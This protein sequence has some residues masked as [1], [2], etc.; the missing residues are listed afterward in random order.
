MIADNAVYRRCTVSHGCR[1]IETLIKET[2]VRRREGF[3]Y[4]GETKNGLVK[5]GKSIRQ[6]PLCRMDQNDL[7]YLGLVWVPDASVFE[8]QLISA[9]GRPVKGEEWF[10]D[11]FRIRDLIAEGWLHG[12]RDLNI[13]LALAYG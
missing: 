7:G 9:M 6:C 5:V 8:Q 3:V 10:D 12:V 13:R 1:Y 2:P 11:P 4:A